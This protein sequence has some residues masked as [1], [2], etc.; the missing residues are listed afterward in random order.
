MS[1]KKIL[2]VD[3]SE[4]TL[5]V[6]K[7]ILEQAGYEVLCRTNPI[8]TGAE[9][10]RERPD[11][12]ILD[13]SMP[14]LEGHE[15]VSVIR[16]SARGNAVGVLL[17]SS[18]PA[19]QLAELTQVSG[20]DGYLR[21]TDDH[22][23]IVDKVRRLL[24]RLHPD[25][26]SEQL[27]NTWPVAGG[28][29]T[30]LIDDDELLLRG[31][32]RA[33]QRRLNMT[34]VSTGHDGLQRILSGTPPACVICDLRL[35]DITG[36]EVFRKVLQIDEQWRNRF[37]FMTGVSIQ[38]EARHSVRNVRTPLLFKPV[39]AERII[40]VVQMVGPSPSALSA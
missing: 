26:Q 20:A 22:H 29:Y 24:A 25:V 16:R 6:L 2:I 7:A 14:L 33:L 1:T 28:A 3:D 21:K 13:V 34:F 8:G 35:P 39:T 38:G 5:Q 30:L 32:Q 12:V 17:Y 18:R 23:A 19:D 36:D 9:V 27:D 37:V 15:V 40:E 31:F 4:I 10:V 11:L